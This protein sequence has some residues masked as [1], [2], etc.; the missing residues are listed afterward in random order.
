MTIRIIY[1]LLFS[2]VSCADTNK[3]P[4]TIEVMEFDWHIGD[5]LASFHMIPYTYAHITDNGNVYYFIN[6]N[7]A[8]NEFKYSEATVPKVD[9]N[10][11]IKYFNT[12]K[13]LSNGASTHAV[14]LAKVTFNDNTFETLYIDDS[15]NQLINN[16]NTYYRKNTFV[17]TLPI[18]RKNIVPVKFD[19]VSFNRKIKEFIKIATEEERIRNRPPPPPNI[20]SIK[21]LEQ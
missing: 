8:R 16:L 13:A 21:Y 1:L 3:K 11:F 14:T 17:D 6:E 20:D 2:F 5:D 15:D 18:D 7:I 9:F 12:K 4:V 19:T 10:D